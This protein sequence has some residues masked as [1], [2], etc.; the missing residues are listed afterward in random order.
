MNTACRDVS[1][2]RENVSI[3]HVYIYDILHEVLYI[4]RNNDTYR[5][6]TGKSSILNLLKVTIKNKINAIIVVLTLSS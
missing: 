2:N 4:N 5:S 1:Y 6:I 3:K